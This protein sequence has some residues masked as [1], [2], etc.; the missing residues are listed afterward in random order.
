[1]PIKRP[2]RLPF[3]LSFLMLAFLSLVWWGVHPWYRNHLLREQRRHILAELTPDSRALGQAI[4][5]RFALLR[6][7]RAFV[8][9]HAF[10]P[11]LGQEFNIFADRLF[12]ES[13][14]IR[15]LTID[16]KGVHRYVYPLAEN[17]VLLGHDLLKDSRPDVRADVKR[18]IQSRE[19]VLSGPYELRSGGLGLVARLAVH[20]EGKFWGL[21]SMA[22]DVSPL[23]RAAGLQEN[24]SGLDV[25]LRDGSGRVLFG[26]SAVFSNQPVLHRL[27][28][29]EGAWEFGALPGQGWQASIRQPLFV[30]DIVSLT[31]VLLLTSLTY[32]L[33]HR[34]VRLEH[35]VE[36]RTDEV[37]RA[38][39]RLEGELSERMRIEEELRKAQDELEER[40][41]QR[42]AAL[43]ET[44]ETLAAEIGERKRTEQERN[45]LLDTTR[46]VGEAKD[47]HSALGV[48]VRKICE[49][50]GWD[51]AEVWIP[52]SDGTALELS[53]A[54][55]GM[56]EALERFRK[57]TAPIRPTSDAGLIVRVWHTKRR[58]WIPD[59]SLNPLFYRGEAAR[60]AGLK[61]ALEVPILAGDHVQAVLGFFMAVAREQESRLVEIVSAVA[62][63]LGSLIQRRRAEQALRESELR[64]QAIFNQTY[65]FVGLL[66]PD[67]ILIEANQAALDFIG[68]GRSDV[69]GR[70]F[71][72]TPWWQDSTE[73][74]DRL[75]EMIAEAAK[76]NFV[77]YETEHRRADGVVFTFDFSL[78]PIFEETGG[79][80]LI[81]SEGRNIA[82]RKRMEEELRRARD[83]L[84][85][86]VQER[87]EELAK[88]NEELRAEIAERHRLQEQLIENG[89]LAAI[90][91]TAAKV[92]HEIGN[93]LNGMSLTA[94]RL[95]RYL[96]G[97][98]CYSDQAVQA[99]LRRLRD[100]I[101]RLNQL[102][103]DFRSL[104]RREHF[105]FQPTSLA[106]IAGEIFAT[107]A[108]N[109]AAK[110]IRVELHFPPDL[111][112]VHVDRDKLKQALWNL[113]K[114][115]VEAMPQG[116][117]L[118]LKAHR[119]RNE[120][121]LEIEDTGVG[122]PPDVDI[123]EPFT[124]T[125]SSG[126]GLGLMVVRQ[127]VSGHGGNLTH[128]STPGKGTTFRLTLPQAAPEHAAV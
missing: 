31:I 65:E 97:Q 28:L 4:G 60:Q 69:V 43:R 13:E 102:L 1:M 110:D 94:Q 86:R 106:M 59:V 50:T 53:P 9:A 30:F 72:E 127:I 57:S 82:E 87:T 120:V 71:L 78:K 54:W 37:T 61:A 16:P 2:T 58:E 112:L 74:Q 126:S 128:T 64:F 76:G 96:T 108:E 103:H 6:G 34:Q 32:L 67:G 19:I 117:T 111:P 3:L 52:N 93:P 11:T 5:R 85:T 84:E 21:V 56:G 29:P 115:A 40:V 109:Y 20:K 38:N 123:F 125:K 18:A 24:A 91:A 51:F 119:S 8:E 107:E 49:A 83:E 25:A 75:Q 122:I 88:T 23:F 22:L 81:I 90:G 33:V 7:L 10:A 116:G 41:R 15:L 79:V 92:A 12:A 47:F 62:S 121:I 70:P 48:V 36:A 63:Q 101:G 66:T 105:Y 26:D 99:T 45:L 27:Q 14:G 100:E 95:E 124:T 113:C 114:N 35:L 118:R 77:R 98:P 39:E 17:E 73:A 44:N 55:Y 68:R 89:R 46:A 104:S 80:A 42:T